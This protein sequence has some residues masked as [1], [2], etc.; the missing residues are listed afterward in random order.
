M[1]SLKLI[2]MMNLLFEIAPGAAVAH[3][4]LALF[5]HL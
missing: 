2:D 3:W 1:Y 5:D 4:F